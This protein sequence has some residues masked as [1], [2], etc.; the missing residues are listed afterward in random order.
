MTLDWLATDEVFSA[1]HA[2]EL[3]ISPTQLRRHR[4]EG[5]AYPIHRGWYAVRP[6]RDERDRHH[7]RLTALLQEYAEL[8]VASHG[9][10][11]VALDLPTER[12][13]L[14]TVHLM[15]VSA[16]QPFRTYSRVRL[17]ERVE[18][19]WL[20]RSTAT[21]DAALAVA[22]VGLADPRSLLV[23]GDAAMR[24]G[25]TTRDRLDAAVS[26]LAGQRGVVAA[27]AAI[28]WCDAR[29]E[30]PGETLTAYV[31]RTLGYAA[32]PQVLIA[33]SEMPG[34]HYVADFQIN[35]TRVLVEF[36]GKVKYTNDGALFAEKKRE[37]ELRRMGYVLVRLTWDTLTNPAEV[38]RRI[39]A[40][41][42]LSRRP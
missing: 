25:A 20:N 4:L 27:R 41:I 10:A 16:E 39:E 22:Q 12:V 18:D 3:G 33:R 36:D 6:V 28:P 35:G 19:G 40:A 38:R 17:H 9:S 5:S 21:V 7:L 15:W 11:L 34:R 32:T 1:A 14:G 2:G 26:A 8:V 37:D 23:A 13:D 31:L 24:C 29:H 30:S 42:A